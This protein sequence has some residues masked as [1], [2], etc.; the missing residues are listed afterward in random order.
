MLGAGEESKRANLEF[1][2]S[3]ERAKSPRIV[4]VLAPVK[5][6]RIA[7]LGSVQK[8]SRS[9]TICADAPIVFYT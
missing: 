7:V 3:E 4:G 8:G 9:R 6:R 2:G 1:G 5:S